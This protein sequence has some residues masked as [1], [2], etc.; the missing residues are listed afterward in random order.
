MR[1]TDQMPHQWAIDTMPHRRR[2]QYELRS[3]AGYFMCI[4]FIYYIFI[5]N[6]FR[7]CCLLLY[8]RWSFGRFIQSITL[9]TVCVYWRPTIKIFAVDAHYYCYN[10]TTYW[11]VFSSI[12]VRFPLIDQCGE[13]VCVIVP[14]VFV[15]INIHDAIRAGSFV[16]V[17]RPNCKCGDCV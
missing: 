12:F 8:F 3:M 6:L 5:I 16:R 11:T 14:V 4:N 17:S 1:F 10:R 9:A 7:F 13:C 15:Y 2:H